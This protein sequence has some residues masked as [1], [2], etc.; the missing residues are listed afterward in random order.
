M[1]FFAAR[2]TA[3]R[4]YARFANFAARHRVAAGRE[5]AIKSNDI[6]KISSCSFA[7]ENFDRSDRGET[8]DTDALTVTGRRLRIEIVRRPCA[9]LANGSLRE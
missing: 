1:V 4:T 8:V 2:R 9:N 6:Q 5:T 3:A 7:D